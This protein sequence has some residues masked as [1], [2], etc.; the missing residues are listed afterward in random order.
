[1]NQ[2]IKNIIIDAIGLLIVSTIFVSIVNWMF[3]DLKKGKPQHDLTVAILQQN[4]EE[5]QKLLKTNSTE[6]VQFQDDN[7]RTALMWACYAYIEDPKLFE[8][9]QKIRVQMV[10]DLLSNPAQSIQM[11]DNDDWTALSWSAWSGLYEVIPVLLEKGAQKDVVDKNGNTPIMLAA[12]RGNDKVVDIL[13]KA[14]ADRDKKNNDGKT[15]LNIAQELESQYQGENRKK[16]TH[17]LSTK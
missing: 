12:F 16:T 14:G 13:L 11:R 7:G 10:Q 8:E 1:M 4:T 9:S 2:Q 5:V 3:A 17:L 6:Q 15:A